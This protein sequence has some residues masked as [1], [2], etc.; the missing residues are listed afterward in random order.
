MNT[1]NKSKI[2]KIGPR[3]NLDP[4]F[5]CVTPENVDAYQVLVTPRLGSLHRTK[6]QLVT[7]VP[8]LNSKRATERLLSDIMDEFLIKGD[9]YTV[10]EL[11]A[12]RIGEYIANGSSGPLISFD[13]E[14]VG[15]EQ[16]SFL[17]LVPPRHLML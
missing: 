11:S 7:L 8:E 16:I 17:W 14:S 9:R 10:V 6:Y 12:E 13:P 1:N 4:D 3:A 15:Y 5:G 2:L